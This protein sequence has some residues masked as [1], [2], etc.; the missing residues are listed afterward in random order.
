MV[1]CSS[2][3]LSINKHNNRARPVVGNPF[4]PVKLDD[5]LAPP[6]HQARTIQDLDTPLFVQSRIGFD[7]CSVQDQV[8]DI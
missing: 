4:V 7:L 8:R 1:S 5:V 6:A 2:K 3:I